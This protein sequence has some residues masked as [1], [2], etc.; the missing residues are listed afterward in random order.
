MS[1]TFPVALIECIRDAR[2]PMDGEV[3]LLAAKIWD[4]GARLL[5]NGTFDLAY[6]LAVQ[7]LSGGLM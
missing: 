2:L 1:A 5:P 4:E 3:A 6:R 7:A